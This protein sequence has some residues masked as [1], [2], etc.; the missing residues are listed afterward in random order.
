MHVQE[1]NI[2]YTQFGTIQFQAFTQRLEI[3]MPHV[4]GG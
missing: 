1:E 4:R 2:V 3:D